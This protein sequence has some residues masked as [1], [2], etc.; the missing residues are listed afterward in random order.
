MLKSFRCFASHNMWWCSAPAF[1]QR[2]CHA[3]V[4]RASASSM[5][6][7]GSA[8][9]RGASVN[10][11]AAATVLAGIERLQ[12]RPVERK[13]QHIGR[14][15]LGKRCRRRAVGLVVD[16]QHLVGR[17]RQPVDLAGDEPLAAA[18]LELAHDRHFGARAR[19]EQRREAGR[20]EDRLDRGQAPVALGVGP[21][22]AGALEIAAA[23]AARALASACPG[24][25]C[26]SLWIAEPARHGK[27]G[28]L[29]AVEHRRAASTRPAPWRRRSAPKRRT[30]TA[31]AAGRRP[32]AAAR[33]GLRQA[34]ACG[35]A[36][37]SAS[38][39][40][41]PPAAGLACGSGAR[42][43]RSTGCVRSSVSG[44]ADQRAADDRVP[45][46]W[47]CARACRDSR[48]R[49]AGPRRASC[50]HR[51]GGGIRRRRDP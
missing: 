37:I 5:A 8:I 3:C 10:S 25:T 36:A 14:R 26:S 27:A 43:R 30:A 38:A 29:L 39:S 9:S 40:S 48:R 41:A 19:R 22:G 45:G 49:S 21:V 17:H 12:Q 11:S 35:G 16:D 13:L 1:K 24:S 23:A 47:G 32:A 46:R 50:R 33:T 15:H 44:D 31:A 4:S 28:L 34:A 7:A 51:A 2:L 18:H 6:A 42:A 20:A